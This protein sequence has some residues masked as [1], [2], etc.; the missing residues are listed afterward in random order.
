[1]FSDS[2]GIGRALAPAVII[3]ALT[4]PAAHAQSPSFNCKRSVHD[5]EIL[6]CKDKGLIALD[7]KLAETLKKAQGNLSAQQ[8]KELAADQ[9]GWIKG[10]NDCWKDQDKRACTEAE[11]T[12]RI[13][14]LQARYGVALVGTSV[15]YACGPDKTEVIFTPVETQPKTANLVRGEDVQ[16]LILQPGGPAQKY[17]G[18]FAVTFIIDGDKATMAWPQDTSVVCVK[19]AGTTGE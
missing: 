4:Q 14:K 18:D 1:M 3:L 9:R 5:I 15:Y 13:V 11:Y 10:R 19:T 8:K 7:R 2:I 17:E 12:R 6:I 16:T